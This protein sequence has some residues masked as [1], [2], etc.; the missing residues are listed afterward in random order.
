[1]HLLFGC[2]LIVFLFLLIYHSSIIHLISEIL[3][4]LAH[5]L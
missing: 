3:Y 5:N 2:F 1:M 4:H